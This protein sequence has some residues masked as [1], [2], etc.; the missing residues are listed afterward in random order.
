MFCKANPD[1]VKWK[2]MASWDKFLA[3]SACRI[4][5]DNWTHFTNRLIDIIRKVVLQKLMRKRHDLRWLSKTLHQKIKQKMQLHWKD[6]K[7]TPCNRK[8]RWDT[9]CQSQ[10]SIQNASSSWDPYE[11]RHIN[12]VEGIQVWAASFV[13]GQ[14]QCV[15]VSGL[16]E[17][18]SWR[19]L[20]D[21]WLEVCLVMLHN[22][23]N[24]Q[25]AIQLYIAR[26]HT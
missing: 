13:A 4:A 22:I 7:A 11:T 18:L 5:S 2:L 16:V 25:W 6:K 23:F 14:H 19:Q 12:L 21:K 1:E 15:C 26:N 9:Y 24:G 20:Q 8:L 3:S 17:G 10:Q